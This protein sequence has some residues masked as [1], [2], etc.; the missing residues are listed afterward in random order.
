MKQEQ[1]K[2]FEFKV[3]GDFALFTDPTTKIGGEKFTYPV[4]TYQALKGITE[5]IYWKPTITIFIDQVRVMNKIETEVKDILVP[6]YPKMDKH[7]LFRYTYLRNAE[8]KVRGH[9][10]FNLQRPDLAKDRNMKKH[11]AI[12]KR[13]ITRG[14]RRD[15]F[16]GTRECQAY[17]VDTK[18][19]AG[20]GY[21][22]HSGEISFGT[23]LHGIDYPDEIGKK[24][25]HVRLW[26]PIMRDGIIDFCRPN[27]CTYIRNVK[28]FGQKEFSLGTNLQS[29]DVLYEKE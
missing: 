19:D 20:E 25:L 23:M 3:F 11:F 8:Y 12:M 28:K 29:V 13:Y 14:G 9:L 15:I 10:E 16:L 5:S 26:D 4:P 24:E 27:D 1:S 6:K 18:F 17:V 21:Y 22:D 7:D 2:S